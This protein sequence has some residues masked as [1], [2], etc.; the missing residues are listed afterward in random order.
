MHSLDL[1][2]HHYISTLGFVIST[3]V[4]LPL[5]FFGC[6]IID[7]VDLVSS[8]HC[9]GDQDWACFAGIYISLCWFNQDD[10]KSQGSLWQLLSSTKNVA[11][12]INTIQGEFLLVHLFYSSSFGSINSIKGIGNSTIIRL[13]F[14]CEFD[15]NSTCWKPIRLY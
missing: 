5:P 7:M 1:Q 4:Y 10:W 9:I 15:F 12:N 13:T 11:I 14:F 3:L 2:Y 8:L 6:L